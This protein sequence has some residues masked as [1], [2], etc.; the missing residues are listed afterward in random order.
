MVLVG[1][2][3]GDRRWVMAVGSNGFGKAGVDSGIAVSFPGGWT[4]RRD[5]WKSAPV[6]RSLPGG[7]ADGSCTILG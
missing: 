1:M 2:G 5:E 6:E 4:F 3:Q 7:K